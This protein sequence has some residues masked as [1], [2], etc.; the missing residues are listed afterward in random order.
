MV[1]WWAGF[2]TLSVVHTTKQF[3]KRRA[4]AWLAAPAGHRNHVTKADLAGSCDLF[5]VHY[6]PIVQKK[7]CSL[8]D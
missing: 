1:V 3:D 8:I 5:A 6:G 2:T 7:F 4:K